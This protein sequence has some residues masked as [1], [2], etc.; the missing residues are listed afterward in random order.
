MTRIVGVR[1][2][3]VTTLDRRRRMKIVTIW[4][5]TLHATKGWRPSGPKRRALSK[6]TFDDLC[7]PVRS[8]RQ[9][10]SGS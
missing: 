8:V 10:Y 5:D 4:D 7:R 6:M 3:T 9:E 1:T 2:T